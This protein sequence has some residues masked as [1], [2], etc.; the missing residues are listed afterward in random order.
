MDIYKLCEHR[1]SVVKKWYY[2]FASRDV[3]PQRIK[4]HEVRVF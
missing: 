2:P 1:V 3:L 4:V